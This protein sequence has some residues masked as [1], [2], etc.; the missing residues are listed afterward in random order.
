M[1]E[2]PGTKEVANGVDQII[3]EYP[4][5]RMDASANLGLQDHKVDQPPKQ[6]DASFGAGRSTVEQIFDWRVSHNCKTPRA[7]AQPVPQLP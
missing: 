3:S 5:Q 7:P 6:G 2:H 4:Y 1:S